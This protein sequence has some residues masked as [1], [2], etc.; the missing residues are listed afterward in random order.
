[1]K[2]SLLL[3]IAY[4]GVFL[5]AARCQHREEPLP[6][7][8][9]A[10]KFSLEQENGALIRSV[11]L[12]NKV[13]VLSFFFTSCHGPCPITNANLQHLAATLPKQIEIV[14]LSTDPEHDTPERL[15]DYAARFSADPTRW[16]F[17]SPP[18]A[19]LQRITSGLQLASPE[20]PDMHS[21]RVYLIDQQGAV[22][23][24]YDG[25][26]STEMENLAKAVPVL[27]AKGN[28]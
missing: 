2:K 25:T 1:M 27:L 11:D 16:H 18:P 13:W 4:S 17:I 28:G 20:P 14:S 8:Q 7:I 24:V 12:L 6:I 26:D 21:T 3:L 22:R 23:A 5:C 19:E 10:P 15:R 9:E